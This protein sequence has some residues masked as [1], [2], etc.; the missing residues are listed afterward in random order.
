MSGREKEIIE[1][2]DLTPASQYTLR[3]ILALFGSRSF[4]EDDVFRSDLGTLLCRAELRIAMGEL[5]AGGWLTRAVR[6]DGSVVHLIIPERVYTLQEIL[7]PVPEEGFKGKGD[8]GPAAE[9]NPPLQEVLFRALT[10]IANEGLALTGKGAI[11]A[12]QLQ[13]FTGA[14]QLSEEGSEGLKG[15]PG[16]QEEPRGAAL[17]LDLL[18]HL[19]LVSRQPDAY[20]LEPPALAEWLDTPE[21]VMVWRLYAAAA[22]RYGAPGTAA[23]HVRCSLLLAGKQNQDWTCMDGLLN[24]LYEE[25]L[26]GG[27]ERERLHKETGQWLRLLRVFGWCETGDTEGSG[28][29]RFRWIG[30][31]P[32]LPAAGSIPGYG[33]PSFGEQAGTEGNGGQACGQSGDG[34]Q[35]DWFVQSDL[36]V[37]VPPGVSFAL[38]WQLAACAELEQGGGWW[39][40]RLSQSALEHA[41]ARGWQPAELIAWLERHSAGGLPPAVAAALQQWARGIGRTALEETLLLSC[42]GREEADLL[43]GHPRLAG[44]LTRLGPLHFSVGG[45]EPALVRLILAEAGIP[46]LRQAHGTSSVPIPRSGG[47]EYTDA[48]TSKPILSARDPSGK[49]NDN[50]L[51]SPHLRPFSNE[52]ED[53]GASNADW[54]PGPEV[55]AA[56]HREWRKYHASTSRRMMELALELGLKVR[57]K[58]AEGEGIFIPAGSTERPWSVSGSALLPARTEPRICRLEPGDWEEMQLI[59]PD[60]AEIPSY[61]TAGQYGMI[62]ES[63]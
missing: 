34:T 33:A 63:T 27:E 55:P 10:Y 14:L 57:L 2:A 4:G 39:T 9:M 25:G 15:L 29:V 54:S 51:L 42:A 50:S 62:G 61:L 44:F 22:E 56:W 60:K 43:D 59:Y 19:G 21:G 12:K 48:R 16:V 3:R 20:R 58:L 53:E 46:A 35:G 23:H 7:Y 40:F 1:P 52:T 11:H 28:P 36:A 24:W 5:R 38:R 47:P 32:V 31:K 30:E 8:A 41:S 37:L 49:G 45:M 26:D 17:A 13:R 6:A 18:L